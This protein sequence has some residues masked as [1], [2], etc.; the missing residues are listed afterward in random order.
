MLVAIAI[1]IFSSQLEKSRDATTVSNLRA[2]YA[3]AQAA[4]LTGT[5]DGT[6]VVVT[7]DGN[8]ITSI[9]VDNVAAKGQQGDF[10]GLDAELPF[11]APAAMGGTAGTYKVTFNYTDGAISTVTATA[12]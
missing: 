4:Y 7:K 2:A 6:H 3:E 11:T 10:S 1:P 9:V 5:G 12:A 8:K